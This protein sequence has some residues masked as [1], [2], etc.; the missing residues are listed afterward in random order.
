VL[1]GVDILRRFDQ[2]AFDFGR[3]QITFWPA[4]SPVARRRPG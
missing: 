1:V 4:R 3:K 2:V